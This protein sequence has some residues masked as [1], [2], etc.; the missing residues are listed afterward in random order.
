MFEFPSVSLS[1][2]I[3]TGPAWLFSKFVA[4]FGLLCA[5]WGCSRSGAEVVPLGKLDHGRV[6]GFYIF[7]K[8]RSHDGR[9]AQRHFAGIRACRQAYHRAPRTSYYLGGGRVSTCRGRG[10]QFLR[11]LQYLIRRLRPSKK[12]MHEHPFALD[13]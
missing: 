1:H 6:H 12:E 3:R 7:C 10:L 5:I 4:A 8:F 9:D 11:D 13:A 2:Y